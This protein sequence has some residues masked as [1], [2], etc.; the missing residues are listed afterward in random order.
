MRGRPGPR[1]LP[2]SWQIWNCGPSCAILAFTTNA[3]KFLAPGPVVTLLRYARHKTVNQSS[4]TIGGDSSAAPANR[5]VSARAGVLVVVMLLALSSL[6]CSMG[7][8]LSLVPRSAAT[9]SATPTVVSGPTRVLIATFTPTPYVPPT[10]TATATAPTPT[11]TPSASATPTATPEPPTLTPTPSALA[12][13]LAKDTNARQGPSLD[14][15]IVGKIQPGSQFD[16]VGRNDNPDPAQRWWYI[17]CVKGRRAWVKADALKVEGDPAGAPIKQEDPAPTP[18]WTW[19]PTLT[20][21]TTPTPV[22]LFYRAIGPQFYL[23]NNAFLKIWVKVYFNNGD[24]MPGYQLKVF[25]REGMDQPQGTPTPV[26]TSTW[27]PTPTGVWTPPP[28]P[29]PTGTPDVLKAPWKDISSGELST[30]IFL[31][32]QPPGFGDRQ[33]FN[34]EFTLFSPGV[35]TYIAYLADGG[36]HP[37]SEPIPFTT[38]PTNPYREVYI[39]FRHIR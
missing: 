17:C 3:L 18:T 37:V 32:S 39:G 30:D 4:P 11:I 6:G 22:P 19:T 23:T 34:L 20:P 21:T 7:G 2:F 26:W 8:A 25:R 15:P 36:G 5:A 27:T 38:E 9:A 13:P 1:P 16:I 33:A 24:P 14:Y 28:T 12:Q 10:P 31:W 29:T 35:G